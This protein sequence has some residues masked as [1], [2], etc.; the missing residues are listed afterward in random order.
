MTT[1]LKTDLPGLRLKWNLW[2]PGGGQ[3]FVRYNVYRREPPAAA[4]TRIAAITDNGTITYT[5]YAVRSGA[6][7]E[8]AVTVTAHVGADDIEGA[9]QSPPPNGVARFEGNFLHDTAAPATNYAQLLAHDIA[10]RQEQDIDF[11]QVW[12]RTAPTAQVG[13]AIAHRVTVSGLPVAHRSDEWDEIASL[14]RRQRDTASTLCLRLGRARH[15]LFC[16]VAVSD[17]AIAQ[18]TFDPSLELQEVFYNEAV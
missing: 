18:K 2:V 7:Y 3:T 13:Q 15:L 4:W 14:V 9:K 16:Q 5:D 12:G 10:L 1:N 11:Q 17:K 8:Y 6:V